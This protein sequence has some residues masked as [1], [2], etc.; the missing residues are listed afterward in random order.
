[1]GLKSGF[2][3]EEW[4]LAPSQLGEEW[5]GVCLESSLLKWVTASLTMWEAHFGR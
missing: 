3:F 2:C 5:S 1:M 4:S